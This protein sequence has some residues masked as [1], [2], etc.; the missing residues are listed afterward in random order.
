ML[1]ICIPLLSLSTYLLAIVSLVFIAVVT[2]DPSEVPNH[3]VS[4]R[5][6]PVTP[7]AL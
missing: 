4:S 6:D 5:K 7:R 3:A 2:V 1:F